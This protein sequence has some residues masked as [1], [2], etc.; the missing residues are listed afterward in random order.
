MFTT[1]YYPH[2]LAEAFWELVMDFTQ[3]DQ[4]FQVHSFFIGEQPEKEV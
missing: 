3:S 1:W 4:K 2:T